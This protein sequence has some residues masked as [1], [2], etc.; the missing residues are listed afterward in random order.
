MSS[1]PSLS[2][3]VHFIETK[4]E[5]H[6]GWRA[7]HELPVGSDERRSHWLSDRSLWE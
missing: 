2:A 4:H 6:A 7:A 1:L 5:P 3:D